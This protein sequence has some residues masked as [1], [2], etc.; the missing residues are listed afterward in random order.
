MRDYGFRHELKHFL[1]I[2]DAAALRPGLRAALKPD[3]FHAD[4]GGAYTIR[5]LYFDDADDSALWEKLDGTDKRVKFRIRYY[6]DDESVI[7]LEKKSK[8]GGLCRKQ[9]ARVAKEQVLSILAGDYAVLRGTGDPLLTEF[10]IRL[11]E[12]RLRPRTLVIYEREAYS[13]RFGNTRLT[14]DSNVRSGLDA[15]NLFNRALP[16]V[17]VMP[18]SQTLL[19]IKYD[20]YLPDFVRMI[21]QTDNRQASSYSKYAACRVC[22]DGAPGRRSEEL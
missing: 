17:R 6:N 3:A 10:Y 12:T 11:T 15:V 21:C 5:S 8:L 9:S 19:E 13:C 7:N 16:T 1:T 22:F 14:L 18:P 20:G 2:S 4:T